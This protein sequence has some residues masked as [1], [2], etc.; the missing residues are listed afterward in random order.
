MIGVALLAVAE[1]RLDEHVGVEDVVAHR[2]EDLVGGVGEADRVG[3][4]LAEGADLRRILLVD[5][6]DTELVGERDR[7]AD[8]GDGQAAA[9]LD[10][11]LDHLLEVH[12]VH[13]VG[14][15][16]D[17]D[18]GL[19]VVDQVQRLVDGVGAAE[20]PVL[21]DALLGRHRSDIVAEQR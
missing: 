19:V 2:G 17:D 4:L 13:V 1:D 15:D 10:V 7:L 21:A 12:A 18:V 14:A 5:L 3:R 6:D 9:G 11:R 16:H 20:V 8:S